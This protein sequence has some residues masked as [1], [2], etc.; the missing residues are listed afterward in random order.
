MPGGVMPR[1]QSTDPRPARA[2]VK[3]MTVARHPCGQL[4]AAAVVPGQPAAD[5]W[6]LP[7]MARTRALL[8]HTGVLEVGEAKMAA[9]AT[10]GPLAYAGDESVT[11]APPTGEMAQG[12]PRLIAAAVT[13]EPP[14]VVLHNAEEGGPVMGWG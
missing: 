4:A 10:R 11:V 7:L 3:V 12:M 8:G 14:T 2:Q 9:R 13:G 6:S 1:G 5:G